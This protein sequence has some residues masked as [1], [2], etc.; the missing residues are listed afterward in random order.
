MGTAT[1]VSLPRDDALCAAV[2]ARRSA[3]SA[4]WFVALGVASGCIAQRVIALAVAIRP[5]GGFRICARRPGSL[6]SWRPEFADGPCARA[7]ARSSLPLSSLSFSL[8]SS[9]TGAIEA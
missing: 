5:S 2:N 9:V 7:S 8:L 4:Q 1:P 3:S 6:S